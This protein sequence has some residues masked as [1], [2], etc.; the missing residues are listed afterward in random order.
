MRLEIAGRPHLTYCTNIH[1]GE[2][3][4]EIRR[5]LEQYVLRVR[6]KVAH[7]GAFGIGLRLSGQ[8]AHALSE[9]KTLTDFRSFLLDHNLYVFTINGFPYGT[10]HGT[11]IKEKVYLPDWLD[12]ERLLYADQLARILTALLADHPDIDGSI[13][14][15]PGAFKS[16]IQSPGDVSRIAGQLLQ[17]AATLHKLKEGTG[18]RIICALEPEP[19][20]LLETISETVTFFKNHLFSSS[21]VTEL[22]KRTGLTAGQAEEALHRHLGVCLDT[23]HAAVEYEDPDQMLSE[24]RDAGIGIAKIQLSAGLRIPQVNREALAALRPFAESTY[25]HQVVERRGTDLI[26]YED[27][28]LALA[29][30]GYA[31]GADAEE[32]EW[33]IHFH[34][35]LFLDRLGSFENTQPFLTRLLGLQVEHAP[36]AHLEIETYTWDVLPEEYRGMPVVDAITRE[37]QWVIG[38]LTQ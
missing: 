36:T 24:L 26:R 3:W 5:N 30:A 35:P 32:K 25:L 6:E 31:P 13:S 8:A 20:C 1:P 12:E 28:P 10:F 16:R 21:A 27:L 38:A 23:C 2:T 37:M 34:V 4:V 15:V 17:H 19:C 9:P 29:N 18:R 14:T 22:S 7:N 33:R 11:H